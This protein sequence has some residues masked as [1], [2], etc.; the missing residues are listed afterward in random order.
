[1]TRPGGSRVLVSTRIDAPPDRV[2]RAF[3]DEIALWWQPSPLF[4]FT[5]GRPG[6][7]AFVSG[8]PRRL[9]ET[10][11]DGTEF[12]VGEVRSWDPPH[13]VVVSWREESFDE[14]Q[15]TE[16]HVR[17]EPV[18]RGTRVVVEHFGWDRIPIDHVARH[19][20]ELSMFQ[21]RFAEWFQALLAGLAVA[22]ER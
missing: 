8:D 4:R 15:E 11:P 1:M 18:D 19:G 12:V 2:F 20:F 22:A 17:F 9:V 6:S 10:K 5:R 7:L 21:R 16:L 14:G 13:R 3:T